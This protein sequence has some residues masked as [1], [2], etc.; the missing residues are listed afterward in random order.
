MRDASEILEMAAEAMMENVEL[1]K[2]ASDEDEPM[3][4]LAG[5]SRISR[6]A[7][8][9]V[10]GSR[11]ALTRAIKKLGRRRGRY[12]AAVGGI[13][14]VQDYYTKTGLGKAGKRL[15]SLVDVL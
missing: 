13:P 9:K 1:E 4:R 7:A 12:N 5:L 3:E 2:L 11:E 10:P 14:G 8:S 15:R 6:L